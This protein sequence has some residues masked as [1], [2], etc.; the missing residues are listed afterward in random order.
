[1][2]L[3]PWRGCT[4]SCSRGHEQ[5]ERGRWALSSGTTAWPSPGERAARAAAPRRVGS[6]ASGVRAG[7]DQLSAAARPAAGAPA[8]GV[9]VEAARPGA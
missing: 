7:L 2:G 4:L 5:I 3:V 8:A 6:R 1:M 9:S